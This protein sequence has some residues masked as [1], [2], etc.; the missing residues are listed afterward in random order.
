MHRVYK[1]ERERR[2]IRL[3]P[4]LFQ[5]DYRITCALLIRKTSIDRT[6]E[7]EESFLS[8]NAAT[9]LEYT[10]YSD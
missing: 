8:M 6:S 7:F 5:S 1:L 10:T 2:Y 4:W 3:H 9:K